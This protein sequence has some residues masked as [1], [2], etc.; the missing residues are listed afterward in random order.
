MFNPTN[1]IYRKATSFIMAAVMSIAYYIPSVKADDEN[2]NGYLEHIENN[3]DEIKESWYI[4]PDE[5]FYDTIISSYDSAYNDETTALQISTKEQ[6]AAFTKAVNTGGKNFNRKYVKLMNDIDLEGNGIKVTNRIDYDSMS[7][8]LT[9]STD[10]TPTNLWKPIGINPLH[11]F[12][13]TFDGQFH[14][15]QNMLAVDTNRLG[16]KAGLFGCC[17][18]ATLRN[19]G[20]NGQSSSIAL[21]VCSSTSGGLVASCYDGTITNCFASVNTYSTGYWNNERVFSGGLVGISSS[22]ITNCYATGNSYVNDDEYS[23]FGFAGG[24]AGVSLGKITSCYAIGC[25]FSRY[26]AGGLVGSLE[27]NNGR[28]FYCFATG[29][30]SAAL[31]Y[32]EHCGKLIGLIG[33]GTGYGC[34]YVAE[35]SDVWVKRAIC[36]SHFVDITDSGNTTSLKNLTGD[37]TANL[38]HLGNGNGFRT[39]NWSFIEGQFPKLKGFK[40]N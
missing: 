17:H 15:V 37:V 23:S 11:S 28:I 33:V 16:A 26:C 9:I 21:S 19:V 2:P 12:E 5:T 39:D 35:D 1:K 27:G 7:F 8:T 32:D 3:L 13:G 29:T 25:S 22:N 20:V 14:E 34:S 30:V 31:T 36:P 40:N 4:Q 10:G 18:G 24:L 6:F 38:Y